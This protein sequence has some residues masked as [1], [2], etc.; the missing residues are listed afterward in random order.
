MGECV[1]ILKLHDLH[2]EQEIVHKYVFIYYNSSHLNNLII[3]RWLL[4]IFL[5]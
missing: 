4:Y 2:V 1:L 3:I 5:K